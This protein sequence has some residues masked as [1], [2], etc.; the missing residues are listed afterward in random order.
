MSG[1]SG[2]Y[3]SCCPRCPSKFARADDNATRRPDHSERP[4]RP[5]VRTSGD[6]PAR[7]G[8]VFAALH[9]LRDEMACRT[10][11]AL[12]A[13]FDLELSWS[14]EQLPQVDADEAR[15]RARARTWGS[16]SP[17][18]RTFLHHHFKPGDSIYDPFVGSG[19]TP[20][21]ANARPTRSNA[22]SLL[23]TVSYR[24]EDRGVLTGIPGN[25]A[26]HRARRCATTASV[27][28]SRQ[29]RGFDLFSPSAGRTD[30][31]PAGWREIDVCA[32]H[33]AHH[34]VAVGTFRKADHALRPGLPA[35]PTR[36]RPSPISTRGPSSSQL[37]PPSSCSATR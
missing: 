7:R 8:D 37:K 12:Y 14:E 10:Q 26:A 3:E 33:R 20:V 29:R 9:E 22:T 11:S 32:R 16:T 15:P 36:D 25:S 17:A 6:R 18:S 5:Q 28:T 13:E 21:K 35:S 34:P 31:V 1:V 24:S 2:L 4:P 19:T 30:R 27:D 23:S